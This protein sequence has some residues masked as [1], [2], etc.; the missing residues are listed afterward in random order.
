M[1][2]LKNFLLRDD[3]VSDLWR[4]VERGTVEELEPA[5][6]ALKMEIPKGYHHKDNLGHT[7]RVLE[8]AISRETDGP[9]LILRTAAVLH[10]IGKPATRKFGK[11]GVVT[12][13]NHEYVGA[14]QARNLLKEHGYTVAERDQIH[15]L[16]T[17]HMRAYGFGD[18]KWTD[19]A[20][21]RL[22]TDAGSLEAL[23]RLIVVFYSDLTS[24]NVK[25]VRK[26]EDGIKR[27]EEA[28]ARVREGDE[29]RALRPA[30][31]GNELM[32]LT[33]MRPGPEFGKL[34]KFLNSDEGVKLSRED[35]LAALRVRFP[36]VPGL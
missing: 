23:D 2:D 34:M 12:F 13:R 22:A 5:L 14:K 20:V 35:A 17:L 6:A 25:K 36:E 19:S 4:M 29:R 18:T 11:P 28:L 24:T 15:H 33:G 27:L 21:R 1:S 7:V 16:I 10:D 3:P 30:I 31:D 8:K 9:D 26:I 32:D